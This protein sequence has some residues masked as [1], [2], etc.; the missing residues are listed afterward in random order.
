M[1]DVTNYNIKKKYDTVSIEIDFNYK[2]EVKMGNRTIIF[3]K[4]IK[5]SKR[6]KNGEWLATIEPVKNLKDERTFKS[7][8]DGYSKLNDVIK[9]AGKKSQIKGLKDFLLSQQIIVSDVHIISINDK[10]H[11][12][13]SYSFMKN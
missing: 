3:G 12:L 4:T 10:D 13:V 11:D 6:T 9:L 7:N 8:Y 5:P 2:G 1:Y